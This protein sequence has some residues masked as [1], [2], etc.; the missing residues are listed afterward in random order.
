MAMKCGAFKSGFT[1][2]QNGKVSPCCVYD[3][4]YYQD[5]T[6]VDWN[7]PFKGFE[8]GR[9]CIACKTPGWTYQKA[10]DQFLH[11]EDF[12]VRYLDVRNSNLCNF[13]C[14]ICC[15]EYSSKWAERLNRDQNF[16]TTDFDVD[17]S[18]VQKIYFA[19]G[20]PLLNK[21]HWDI[22]DA[23][24]DPSK[25]DLVYSTNLSTLHKSQDYWPRFQHVRVNPSLDGIGKFGEQ[26]RLGL[27][28]DVFCKNLDIVQRMPNVS[29]EIN[30]T[31]NLLNIWDLEATDNWAKSV[32]VNIQYHRLNFPNYLC[33]SVLPEEFKKQIVY[34]PNDDNFADKLA[35]DNSYMFDKTI[36]SILLGDRIRGTDV[37]SYL[38]YESY[39]K[40]MFLD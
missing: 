1:I 2:F 37:W 24:E 39:A 40:K 36:T 23:I 5:I 19:G 7:D 31:V 33:L 29:V 3:S 20:E 14:I 21:K 34:T 38:P 17:L 30:F 12:A 18:Q 13:E 25:V 8:D 22:L 32:G 28:W 35:E 11:Y 26:V 15:P 16:V 9:G 27:N 10:F 6:E 4:N